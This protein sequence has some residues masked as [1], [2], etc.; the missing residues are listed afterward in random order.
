M[1]PCFAGLVARLLVALWAGAAVAWCGGGRRRL[2]CGR[3][4]PAAAFAG[5]AWRS[6]RCAGCPAG[7]WRWVRRPWSTAARRWRRR[8]LVDLAGSAG[9]TTAAARLG[10]GPRRW[11]VA[12]RAFA[13]LVTATTGGTRLHRAPRRRPLAG[14][15]PGAVPAV[16]RRGC[17]GAVDARPRRPR[18]TPSRP[19]RPGRR[20]PP[21]ARPGWGRRGASAPPPR[22]DRGWRRRHGRGG[23]RARSRRAAARPR[24]RAAAPA[25]AAAVGPGLGDLGLDRL[26]PG[27]A[28]PP[29]RTRAAPARSPAAAG[30]APAPRSGA[31][32]PGQARRG[33]RVGGGSPR[34]LI[35]T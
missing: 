13:A 10:Q 33:R 3:R 14:R 1:A 18:A 30:R 9:L 26:G 31:V 6:W 32:R 5:A 2:G 16:R 22:G 28:R 27:R 8:S 12:F 4:P 19:W 11:P 17:A 20:R 25:G 24:P 29:W 15:P 34:A 21:P 35:G 23:R 7:G